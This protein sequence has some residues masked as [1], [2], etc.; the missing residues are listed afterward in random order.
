MH[1]FWLYFCIITLNRVRLLI[2]CDVFGE[3]HQPVPAIFII[4]VWE[5]KDKRERE[6]QCELLFI[7]FQMLNLLYKIF[8]GKRRKY[9]KVILSKKGTQ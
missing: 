8:R 1:M 4:R 3:L 9:E 2:G 5:R 6:I 7:V